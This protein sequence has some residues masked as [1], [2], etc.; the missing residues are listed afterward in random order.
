MQALTHAANMQQAEQPN[1]DPS[2]A[3]SVV[4]AHAALYAQ[5]L[6][7]KCRVVTGRL[8]PFSLGVDDKRAYQALSKNVICHDSKVPL[9]L[10]LL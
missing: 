6:V 2:A 8:L 1:V 7:N 3:A 5:F 9:R 4:W 10:L